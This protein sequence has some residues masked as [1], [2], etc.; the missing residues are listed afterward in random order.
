MGDSCHW[1][2]VIVEVFDSTDKSWR[3]AGHL[4]RDVWIIKMK[5][6]FSVESFYCLTMAMSGNANPNI[7]GFSIRD[8]YSIF[9]ALSR[10]NPWQ[11]HDASRSRVRVAG[12]NRWVI[13]ENEE[14]LDVVIWEFEKVNLNSSSSSSSWK[15]ITKMPSSMC[16]GF[17]RT[18][19]DV[20]FPFSII[21]VMLWGIA[22][23]LSTMLWTL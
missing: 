22:L 20:N 8:G 10:D 21:Q 18:L 6:A 9:H 19:P 12:S 15:E 14:L 13:S 1:G 2:P 5:M 16:E 11:V 17:N 4:P 23:S 3:I 7:L